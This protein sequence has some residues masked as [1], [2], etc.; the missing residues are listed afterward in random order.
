MCTVITT[1]NRKHTGQQSESL[2]TKES[3]LNTSQVS[4]LDK[5]ITSTATERG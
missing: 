3:V 1:D 5:D 4:T 2:G